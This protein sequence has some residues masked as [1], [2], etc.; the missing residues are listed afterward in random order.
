MSV[1]GVA[2]LV[3]EAF[4]ETKAQL[5]FGYTR[6][7]LDTRYHV[8]DTKLRSLGWIPQGKLAEDIPRLVTA[9]R[10]TFRW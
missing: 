5:D 7:G 2:T 1:R 9:E 6:L 8:D 10:A 3:L 4:G